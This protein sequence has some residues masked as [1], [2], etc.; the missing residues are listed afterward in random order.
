[1]W[2]HALFNSVTRQWSLQR[3]LDRCHKRAQFSILLLTTTKFLLQSSVEVINTHTKLL[4]VCKINIILCWWNK[5]IFNNTPKYT[6]FVLKHWRRP[7]KVPVGTVG[8]LSHRPNEQPRFHSCS[9]RCPAWICDAGV[10]FFPPA[11]NKTPQTPGWIRLLLG[12]LYQSLLNL[13]YFP[14]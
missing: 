9:C 13:N 14:E 1:M 5:T 4:L 8:S 10:T 3:Y 11:S 7:R 12:V 2:S 6:A